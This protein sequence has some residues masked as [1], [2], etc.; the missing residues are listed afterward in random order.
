[1]FSS[2]VRYEDQEIC[3]AERILPTTSLTLSCV[4]MDGVWS[5]LCWVYHSNNT[6]IRKRILEK[7]VSLWLQ[8]HCECIVI[9]G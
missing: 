4:R 5:D 1:M 3:R 8:I 2:H 7:Y 6:S 9:K